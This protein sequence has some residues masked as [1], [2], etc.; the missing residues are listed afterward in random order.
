MTNTAMA[1]AKAAVPY[2]WSLVARGGPMTLLFQPTRVRCRGCTSE[3]TAH[4]QST[5]QS[6]R[7]Q[8]S[9]LRAPAAPHATHRACWRRGGVQSAGGRAVHVPTLL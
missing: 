3:R 7:A 1:G 8:A 4:A 9:L 2:R 6:A 5:Q